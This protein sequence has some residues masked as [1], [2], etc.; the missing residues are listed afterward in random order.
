M[1]IVKGEM[2]KMTI[3]HE[4][5]R[6]LLIVNGRLVASMPPEVA[7]LLARAILTKAREAEELLSATQ[8]I[9][10]QAMLTRLGVGFGLTNRPD[11]LRVAANEAAWNSQLRR[12]IPPA[13]AI[14]IQT[15]EVFGTPS[16]VNH[17]VGGN[18]GEEN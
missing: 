9:A 10:D 2:K 6:V 18:D 3:R 16:I 14:G 12:Y 8:I 17:V 5:G 15:Q 11:M 13:K 4:N 7:D 1:D